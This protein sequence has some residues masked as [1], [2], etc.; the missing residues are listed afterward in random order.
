MGGTHGVWRGTGKTEAAKLPDAGISLK[1]C[2]GKM[3]DR[4]RLA[5]R[6][7]EIGVAPAE[8]SAQVNRKR[9][10]QLC[11]DHHRFENGARF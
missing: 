8:T 6:T 10:S 4:K 9:K 2:P 1:Q 3:S 5:Y 11:D 7:R